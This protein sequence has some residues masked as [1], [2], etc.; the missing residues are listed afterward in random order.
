MKALHKIA[1][2]GIIFQI[3]GIIYG[4]INKAEDVLIMS[5][6]FLFVSCIPLFDKKKSK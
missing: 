6:I 1:I 3:V 2:I 4:I 5:L